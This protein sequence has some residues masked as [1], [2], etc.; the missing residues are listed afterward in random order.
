MEFFVLC[1]LQVPAICVYWILKSMHGIISLLSIGATLFVCFSGLVSA[2]E[3]HGFF[4]VM[5]KELFGAVLVGIIVTAICFPIFR[6]AEDTNRQI[7]TSLLAVALAYILCEHFGFSGAIACV[8]CGILFSALRNQEEQKGASLALE[9]FDIFWEVLDSLLNSILYVIL[10]L[11]FLHILQ[12][13]HVLILSLITIIANF[14]GRAGSLGV[15][16]LFMGKSPLFF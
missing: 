1:C 15:T 11:S 5:A 10:G 7:F 8:V 2:D 14:I 6:K 12:M 16:S 13:P 4:A 9:Q 3:N